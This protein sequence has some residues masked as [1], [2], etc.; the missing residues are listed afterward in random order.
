MGTKRLCI[1]KAMSKGGYSNDHVLMV[2]DAPGDDAASKDNG[3]LFY[4][5]VPSQE[6]E[7]WHKLLR[8]AADR[9]HAGT[10]AGDYMEALLTE[11]YAVLRDQ[12]EW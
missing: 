7:S 2:G 9:F 5:I 11:F 1:E 12:P 10:Y 4:P 6:T 3:V 8:E